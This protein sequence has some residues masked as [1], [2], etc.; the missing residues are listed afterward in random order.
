MNV[1]VDFCLIPIGGKPSFSEYIAQCQRILK[2]AN[3]S[4]E[5]H[6]FGTTI[7][8]EWDAVMSAV[9]RCTEAVHGMGVPRVFTTLKIGTRTDRAQ[10]MREKVES[11]EKLL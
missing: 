8:G 11:V 7:E 10:T 3:L 2:A 6:P 9:R 1:T 4:H 5:L